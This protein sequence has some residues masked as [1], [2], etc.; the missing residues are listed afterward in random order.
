MELYQYQKDA[1]DLA[2]T[3]AHPIYLAFDMGLGKSAIALET[4]KRRGVKRLLI[5]CPAIGKLAW[6]KEIARWWPGVKVKIVDNPDTLHAGGP[7]VFILPYSRVS[8]DEAYADAVFHGEPFEMTV[9]DEAHALKNPG[10]NRTKAVLKIMRPRLGFVL[11]MSGTP[12]PNHAGELFPI[13]RTVFPETVRKS[14]GQLMKQTEFE[15]TYC[16]VVNKWVPDYRSGGGRSVRVIEGTK[17]GDVLKARIRPYFLRKTK[18]EAL[19]E[20]PDMTFD[21]YPISAPGAPDWG[22]DFSTMSDDEIEAYMSSPE[23]H[24]MRNRHLT[25]IAKVPGAVEAI[26]DMLDSCRRK[27]LV[28]AHHADVIEKLVHD[29]AAYYPVSLTGASSARERQIAVDSFLIDPVCR[30]FVGN[31]TAAGTSIT[32]VG[33][34]NDVSDV[35]FVEADY[36]PGNNVQAASRIHRIGQKDAVQVWFLTASGTIDDRIQD[37][38]ARKAADFKQLFG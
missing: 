20:L 14:D 24:V 32:L 2:A 37:I 36:S 18:K 38:L 4:A 23:A 6:A 25:G 12:T 28:F 15:D 8:L 29:L 26:T 3:A 11:P 33:D 30:V 35:F 34:K 16:Q 7:G 31:I 17:N 10:A 22:V 13:L 19:P 5:M 1:V 21:T 9:L 27:V